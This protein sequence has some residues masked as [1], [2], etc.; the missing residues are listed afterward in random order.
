MKKILFFAFL[1]LFSSAC[2]FAQKGNYTKE[3]GYVDISF[4]SEYTSGDNGSEVL[5]EEG[6]MKMLAQMTGGNDSSITGQ[7]KAIKLIHLISFDAGGDVI[8]TMESKIAD[9][10]R[11]LLSK[12]WDRI[13]KTKSDKEYANIYVKS[14]G[15]GKFLG[16][17]IASVNYKSGK[18]S[19]VNI[20]GNIDPAVIGKL[21]K[22]WKLPEM[23][24]MKRDKN[25]G[26]KKEKED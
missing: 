25:N 6:M 1:F 13:A 8:K 2:L 4:L 3:P 14:S 22:E 19:F 26:E 5:I 11:D 21:P 20:V 23:L 18:T 24:K 17:F 9:I 15:D 10:D 16:L 12:N 7:L